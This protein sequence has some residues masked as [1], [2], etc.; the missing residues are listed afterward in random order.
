MPTLRFHTFLKYTSLSHTLFGGALTYTYM[1][2]YILIL[3]FGGA[4]SLS[5]SHTHTYFG[6]ALTHI[7]I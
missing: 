2:L 3:H 6:G 5:L 7:P 4:L 1:R